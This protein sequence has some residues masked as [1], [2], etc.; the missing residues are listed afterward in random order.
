MNRTNRVV[1]TCLSGLVGLVL[2]HAYASRGPRSFR[3]EY[4]RRRDASLRAAPPAPLV[5][6]RDLDRLPEPVQTYVRRAGALGRPHV[7]QLELSLHGRI[8]SGPDA[9]WMTF[10]GQQFS[11]FGER[12]L[13]LFH[14][15]ARKAGVPVDVLHVFDDSG[16]TMRVKALSLVP[17]VSAAGPEM[18]RAETVTM[19]N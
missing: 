16:A 4:R 12:P 18:D 8:R 14:L 10:T 2:A 15:D 6:D 11:K 1:L 17:M 3:A 9:G 19:L 13:R 5:T 7:R